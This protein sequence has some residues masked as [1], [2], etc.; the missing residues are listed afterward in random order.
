MIIEVTECKISPSIN[1]F[2]SKSSTIDLEISP[3]EENCNQ[4]LNQIGEYFGDHYILNNLLKEHG[5]K[6][7]RE[8]LE[9]V[10]SKNG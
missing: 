5:I 3:T 9:E 8:M 4:I 2:Y 1:G 6:S 7:L 10:I